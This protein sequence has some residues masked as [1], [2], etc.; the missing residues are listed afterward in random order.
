MYSGEYTGDTGAVAIFNFAPEEDGTSFFA[1]AFRG[2]KSPTVGLRG[3]CAHRAPSPSLGGL[4]TGVLVEGEPERPRGE[5]G[6]PAL[7]RPAWGCALWPPGFVAMVAT[8]ATCSMTWT[9]DDL[10]CD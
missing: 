7:G 8:A 10:D 2:D 9:L 6:R 4:V 1:M 3:V 5:A